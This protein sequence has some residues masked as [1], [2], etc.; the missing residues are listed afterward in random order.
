MQEQMS[1]GSVF[2]HAEIKPL[3]KK[4]HHLIAEEV[5]ALHQA[6]PNAILDEKTVKK[7]RN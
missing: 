7:S 1:S 5:R 2:Y 6:Y 3:H 4:Q